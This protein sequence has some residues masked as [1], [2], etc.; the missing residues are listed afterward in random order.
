MSTTITILFL[1]LSLRFSGIAQAADDLAVPDIIAKEFTGVY[2]FDYLFIE[3]GIPYVNI[4]GHLQLLELD[5]IEGA[6]RVTFFNQTSKGDKRAHYSYVFYQEGD[7]L[8]LR[9][10]D[11][12]GNFR[13][14]CIGTYQPEKK[15]LE[16]VAPKAAKPARDT[17]SPATRK[18]GLF[19][20]PTSWPAYESLNRH[21]FFRVYD[22]GFV[23][24]Q[25]NLKLDADGKIVARETGVITA[26]KVKH[27]TTRPNLDRSEIGRCHS[28]RV[29]YL[30]S[31]VAA[32]SA[33]APSECEAADLTY[34]SFVHWI[35]FTHTTGK[36][37]RPR[38]RSCFAWRAI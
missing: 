32:L 11:G 25:E 24:V 12:K 13:F 9:E 27:P 26:V 30:P 8:T 37:V 33:Q 20:R 23:N 7:K 31:R 17:D 38:E 14:N 3:S 29:P 16:C 15:L 6:P 2:R 21:N 36:L 28:R 34:E 10:F 19:K 4:S 1:L 35:K 18:S 5:S 22:W